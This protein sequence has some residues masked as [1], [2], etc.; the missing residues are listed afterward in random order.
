MPALT[1]KERSGMVKAVQEAAVAIS[2]MWAVLSAI[3]S[4]YDVDFPETVPLVVQFAA[5]NCAGS[6][7]SVE[8][9]DEEMVM[10]ALTECLNSE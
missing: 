3:E 8:D 1:A 6:D 4:K 7:A 2:K 9:I 5:N 10:E